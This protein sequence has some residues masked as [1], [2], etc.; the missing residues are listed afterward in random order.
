MR[1]NWLRPFSKRIENKENGRM[2]TF[3]SAAS[4]IANVFAFLF[5]FNFR[6]VKYYYRIRYVHSR[7]CLDSPL[8]CHIWL[9]RR[10][11]TVKL[12][13]WNVCHVYFYVLPTTFLLLL[14]LPP[15]I[16][17]QCNENK[18]VCKVVDG[19]ETKPHY[20]NKSNN[21]NHKISYYVVGIW[22]FFLLLRLLSTEW[23]HSMKCQ[24]MRKWKNLPKY[25]QWLNIITLILSNA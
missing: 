6:G 13:K 5:S 8:L 19:S 15:P 14:L 7:M 20:N 12:W 18:W 24:N 22:F 23:M 11:K 2:V 10:K 3:F 21:H 1:R 9:D 4:L 25:K 17:R 16:L